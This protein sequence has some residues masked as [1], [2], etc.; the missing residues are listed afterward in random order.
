MLGYI[1]IGETYEK[2][3]TKR[4][5]AR[6]NYQTGFWR[7][8]SQYK[9]VTKD[10]A[11]VQFIKSTVKNSSYRYATTK[12]LSTTA[13][14][15]SVS[16]QTEELVLACSP[17]PVSSSLDFFISQEVDDEA[18]LSEVCSTPSKKTKTATR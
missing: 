4:A 9:T 3:G 7:K 1:Y 5:K 11:A 6:Y 2:D 13:G 14:T 18:S 16:V 15:S 8:L 10:D 17:T 12:A